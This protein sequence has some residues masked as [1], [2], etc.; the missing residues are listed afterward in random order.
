LSLSLKTLSEI[1]YL[2]FSVSKSDRLLT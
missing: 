2:S 1:H